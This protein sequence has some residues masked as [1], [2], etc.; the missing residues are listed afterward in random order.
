MCGHHRDDNIVEDFCDTVHAKV[1][2]LFG[3]DKTALQLL[4]FFDDLEVCNL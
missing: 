1:H 3:R 2:P 4:L